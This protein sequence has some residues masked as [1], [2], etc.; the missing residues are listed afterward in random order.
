MKYLLKIL[1]L[2]FFAISLSSCQNEDNVSNTNSETELSV[3][4]SVGSTVMFENANYYVVSNTIDSAVNNN[5]SRAVT[6]DISSLVKTYSVE[7]ATYYATKYFGENILLLR[8]SGKVTVPNGATASYKET[9]DTIQKGLS[10]NE[11]MSDYFS[12]LTETTKN[13]VDYTDIYVIL[14]SAKEQ[15]GTCRVNWNSDLNKTFDDNKSLFDLIRD[16]SPE[17]IRKVNPAQYTISKHDKTL[18]CNYQVMDNKLEED[19]RYRLL[20]NARDSLYVTNKRI[21]RAATLANEWDADGNWIRSYIAPSAVFGNSTMTAG[22]TYTIRYQKGE[23]NYRIHGSSKITDSSSRYDSGTIKIKF[24][25]NKKFVADNITIPANSG[26]YSADAD[27][28]YDEKTLSVPVEFILNDD[29]SVSFGPSV[30]AWVK[31]WRDYIISNH[32]EADVYEE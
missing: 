3:G 16:F 5:S 14:N 11:K 18:K 19:G 20:E 8:T 31:N 1:A 28:E 21:V 15:I 4:Y 9:Y 24:D 23:F 17:M 32:D 30:Y 27:L 2:C 25:E 26:L 22:I 6:E 29:G 10:E 13:E 12:E 7:R